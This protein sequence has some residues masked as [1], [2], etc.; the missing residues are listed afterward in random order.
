M[1][2]AKHIV[3]LTPGFAANE[4]DDSCIP[5]MQVFLEACAARHPGLKFS[6]IAF[7]YP[8]T[9][10]AYTWKGI[11]VYPCNGRN[12]KWPARFFT[13]KKAAQIFQAIHRE[14]PV[15]LIHSFW[16]GECALAGEKL[17]LRFHLA[18]ICTLMGQDVLPSNRYLRKPVFE[19]TPFIALCERHAAE[20]ENN[21]GRK[22][23]GIIPWG[24]E[25]DVVGENPRPRSF[26]ILAA[27]SLIPLKRYDML[28]RVVAA[29]RAG[30]PEMRVLIAGD[31]PEKENLQKLSRS[32][33]VDANI[34]FAGR[35]SRE[36]VQLCMRDSKILLHPSEFESF[37]YVFAEALKNGMNIV[38]F[39]VGFAETSERW[40]VARTE[41]EMTEAVKRFLAVTNVSGII[42]HPVAGTADRYAA[43]YDQNV[44][45]SP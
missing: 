41:A 2:S 36:E 35:L 18:H 43:L 3:L 26:D 30:F 32:L 17:A 10:E 42:L 9:P 23:A 44:S 21:T 24:I 5:P 8:F 13:L 28:V 14:R 39:P 7:H 4:A 6:V 34:L 45:M 12:R 19:R 22:P 27:G 40:T 15:D 33:G 11:P 31:G 20:F 16:L 25:G 29:L 37:G 1:S 38:S